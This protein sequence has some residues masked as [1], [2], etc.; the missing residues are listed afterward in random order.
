MDASNCKSKTKQKRNYLVQNHLV[1]KKNA[2]VPGLI[3]IF[4]CEIQTL[5]TSIPFLLVHG[6]PLVSHSMHF[7]L[8]V[9]EG[10]EAPSRAPCC[11]DSIKYWVFEIPWFY[12]SHHLEC[13]M[14]LFGL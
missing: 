14:Y 3:L 12:L 5:I 11:I 7:S 6:Y 10:P 2:E 1:T 8:S 9:V 4:Q 13:T